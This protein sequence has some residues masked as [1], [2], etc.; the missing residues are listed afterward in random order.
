MQIEFENLSNE[1]F[2]SS[3]G[4]NYIVIKNKKYFKNI[5]LKN[6]SIDE[7][8]EN[9]SLFSESLV[10]KNIREIASKQFD[11]MLFGTGEKTKGLPSK[12]RELLITSKIPHE[13][14]NSISA[15]KTYN[16]LLSQGRKPIAFLKLGS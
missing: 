4:Q 8:I 5:I 12:T 11:F 13:I 15:F 16:I 10:K 6:S 2:I 14:M 9:K 7:N 1:N 3:Y